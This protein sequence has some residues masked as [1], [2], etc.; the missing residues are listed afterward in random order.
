[1]DILTLDSKDGN[2]RTS[3]GAY[4][5]SNMKQKV[6]PE[7]LEKY[8]IPVF[9]DNIITYTNLLADQMDENRSNQFGKNSGA[10]SSWGWYESKLDLMSEVNVY[11]STVWSSSGYDIGIDNR[12]YAIFQLKPEF[13]N[14]YENSRFNYWLKAVGYSTN[15]DYVNNNGFANTSGASNLSGIK[16]RFLIN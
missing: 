11:G 12:Q 8:I 13:I 1:M 5:G 4:V 2:K 15:F 6:L 3:I 14:S 7:I 9:G 16:P 10:S